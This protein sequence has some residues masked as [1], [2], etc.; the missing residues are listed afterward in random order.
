MVAA[1]AA[2]VVG[3]DLLT[4]AR[5]QLNGVAGYSA[6]EGTRYAGIGMV[7]M[8]VFFAGVLLTSGTLAQLVPQRNRPLL[9]GAIGAAGVLLVG[10]PALGADAGGA[11]ALTAGVCLTAAL[12]PGGW[13]TFKRLA[14]AMLAGLA[15]TV[16]FALVDVRQPVDQQG[17]LGRFLTQLSDGTSGLTLNRLGDA[18]RIALVTS[19]LTVLALV[20]AV[21]LWVVL[22]RPWGGLKRLY[23]IY[24][25]IRAAVAG[26]WLASILGGLLGG[27]ALNVMGAA[28]ATAVPVLTLGAMRVLGHAADR[29]RIALEAPSGPGAVNGDTP[30]GPPTPAPVSDDTPEAVSGT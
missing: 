4:G 14:L 6:L 5:L 28:A 8:G 15:A 19:P 17:S 30:Q 11:V 25:P 16:V 7:G 27:A 29:T 3:I 20:S 2:S 24:P 13:L 1:I 26:M 22:M 12:C 10:I 23:G 21:F 18:N 9:V